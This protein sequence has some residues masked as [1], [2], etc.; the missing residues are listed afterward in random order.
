MT[1][2]P[3]EEA[4]NGPDT[5]DTS[6]ILAIAAYYERKERLRPRRQSSQEPAADQN[7]KKEANGTKPATAS[8]SGRKRKTPPKSLDVGQRIE[9]LF[10]DPPQYFPGTIMGRVKGKYTIEYDDGDTEVLDLDSPGVKN[11]SYRVLGTATAMEKRRASAGKSSSSS[12]MYEAR[13][14]TEKTSA[15][16]DMIH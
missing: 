13:A 12:I 11:A 3:G 9:V 15:M 16:I 2:L 14:F 6:D 4:S 8:A 10:D 5:K 7:E 1:T